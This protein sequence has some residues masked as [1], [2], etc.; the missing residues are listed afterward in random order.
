MSILIIGGKGNMGQRYQAVLRYLSH[1]FEIYDLGSKGSL[2]TY[3]KRAKGV[4]IASPTI[5]HV[6]HIV[7]CAASGIPILCEKPISKDIGLVGAALRSV[8]KVN[9]AL[10]MVFNYRVMLDAFSRKCKSPT[11][12][13]Y[14]KHGGD[15]LAWD[16]IQIIGLSN[17]SVTLREQSPIWKCSINGKK[18]HFAHI[19]RSYIKMIEYWTQHPKQDLGEILETHQKTAELARKYG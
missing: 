17:G 9:G 14:F 13:D 11:H 10:S 5:K 8:Y 16:C 6:E 7:E 3:L 2:Q 1:D 19:D 15:G 12:F 18:L 4:I